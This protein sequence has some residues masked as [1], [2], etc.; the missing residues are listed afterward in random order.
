MYGFKFFLLMFMFWSSAAFAK[1]ELPPSSEIR[2]L[3]QS[4]NNRT[5]E[6]GTTIAYIP[7]NKPCLNVVAEGEH[8]EFCFI[9]ST[10][11]DLSKSDKM[12]FYISLSTTVSSAVAFEYNTL[13]YSKRCRYYVGKE[14]P[15]CD[16][17]YT[18]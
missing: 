4:Y 16:E 5:G 6:T 1:W 7:I 2:E 13:W 12:G 3:Q 9:D 17:P 14:I 10:T 11:E 8:K 15:T 18:N